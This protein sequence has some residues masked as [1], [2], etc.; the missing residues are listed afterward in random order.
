MKKL[1]LLIISICTIATMA[2]SQRTITGTVDDDNGEPLI[3]ANVVV[4]GTTVGTTTDFDGK[5]SL[6]VPEGSEILTFSYTGFEPLDI[7]IGNR[8]I[9]DITLSAGV[10]LDEVVVT[11]L[12]ISRKEKS[13]GYAVQEVGGDDIKKANTVSAI[14]ALA[15]SAAGVQVT[16]SSGAAGAP[17]RI[18][19]RGQTSFNGDNEALIVVD[20][21][22]M[23]NDE[24]H[25]ERSLG[26]V[27]NSNRGIDLNPNDIEKVTVLKGAAATA[28]Y[29]IEG[30][31]GVVLITTK[32]GAGKGVSVD[33]QAG[34]TISQVNNIVGLQDEYV[35]GSGGVW[36]GP[37]TTQSGSWGP[38]KS[39]VYWDG[40]DY[41]WD[42]NGRLTTTPTD[43]PFRP[44]DNVDAFYRTGVAANTNV[45]LS[46]GTTFGD[47]RFSFGYTDD[48][49]VTPQNR[50]KRYNLGLNMG[51][52]LLN[53]KLSVRFNANY[54]NSGGRRVQ[55]G[56]NTSG[57][58][59]GLLRT[60]I[61][62]DNANGLDDPV[63]YTL[64]DAIAD[65]E[66]ANAYQ[67]LDN[68]Q[69]NY[70]GGLGYDN[71]FW[72]V[73]N[74]PFNDNVNRFFGNIT[75]SYAINNWVNK[76]NAKWREILFICKYLNVNT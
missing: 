17:S 71:P 66:N 74:S 3:G 57:V 63:D 24:N 7:E 53:D 46:G 20:G 43:N 22:R 36:Q 13:L 8:A 47:Y 19:I 40:S 68:S 45:A 72:V 33:V 44:Y 14:D 52:K 18:V 69:R 35:Q 70:R 23:S 49:G 41:D 51:T 5:Y 2:I 25:T 16:S 65:G 60:A 76:I 27:A 4:K 62:F 6:E 54:V 11:A 67:F 12:G 39:E 55:Q 56:S 58:M 50:F 32:R 37:E 31:R 10:Q 34:V 59:L 64:E 75:A 15:G 42:K 73:N 26:G 30:A 48:N 21:V 38:H 29:G 1:L 28:L 61:S 9:V